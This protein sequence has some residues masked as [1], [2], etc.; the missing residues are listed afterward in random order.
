[1]VQEQAVVK[2]IVI[3]KIKAFLETPDAILVQTGY[4]L[5]GQELTFNSGW[6][7]RIATLEYMNPEDVEIPFPLAHKWVT[8]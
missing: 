6:K 1:M 3:E 4:A 8:D 5:V 7:W 2:S